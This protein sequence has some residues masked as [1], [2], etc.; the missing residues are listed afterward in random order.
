MAAVEHQHIILWLLSV[1][2]F[3]VVMAGLMVFLVIQRWHRKSLPGSMEPDAAEDRLLCLPSPQSPQFAARRATTWLAIKTGSVQLVQSALSLHDPKPCSWAE[4]LS[5]DHEQSLFVSPPVAGWILVIGPALPDPAEDVD[6]CY[7]FLADLSRKLGHVQF[8]HVHHILNH[9]AWVRIDAGRVIRAYAWAGKTL[10][11]QG[12]P[13]PAE[14]TLHMRCYDY[15][16]TADAALLASAELV[17]ANAEKVHLLAARWSLDPGEPG[18]R[19][20]GHERGI[21]GEASGFF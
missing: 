15:G 14:H 6:V 20:V 9:H 18:L 5:G 10:W 11:N 2:C 21:I 3:V 19:G 13:T 8:F 1:L 17:P 12:P 16:E 4:G 7:R